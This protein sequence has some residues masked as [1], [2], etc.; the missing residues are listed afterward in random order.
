[1]KQKRVNVK[2][3]PGIKIPRMIN[4]TSNLSKAIQDNNLIVLATPSEYLAST[5]KKIKRFNLSEKTFCSVVKGI[6]TQSLLRMSQ[7]IHK[8][9]GNVHLGVLSGPTIA[10]EVALGVPSTAVIA[11]RNI[12]IAKALQKI[13]HS[14]TFRIYRSTDVVGVELGGSLKNVIALASGM[15]DGLGFGTNTKAAILSR[16]LAEMVR[17]GTILGAKH[18]TF[19]GLSGLGDLVTTCMSPRSRNR[20]VGERLGRGQSITKILNSMKMV[21]E[22]VPTAKAV[23]R[24]SQRLHI[25]MPITKEVYQIIY[26]NKDPK[27]AVTD[28]MTRE[29]KAE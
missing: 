12:R 19:S 24:L 3:L 13:F 14:H 26:K 15:C 28:L 22:G 25:S 11:S 16:G 17:L 2:F 21:A 9:L 6:H 29:L 10:M 7:I 4:L 23:Y 5:L 27:R 8:E 1:M 20:T 18:K